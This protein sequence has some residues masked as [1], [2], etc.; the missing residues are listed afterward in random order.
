[1]AING[2][3]MQSFALQVRAAATSRFRCRPL[4]SRM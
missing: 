2:F 4:S 3:A 1:M